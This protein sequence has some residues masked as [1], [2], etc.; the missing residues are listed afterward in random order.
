VIT[1][2]RQCINAIVAGRERHIAGDHPAGDRIFRKYMA[3]KNRMRLPDE[4]IRNQPAE[5]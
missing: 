3:A 5:N 1:S 4:R 2:R